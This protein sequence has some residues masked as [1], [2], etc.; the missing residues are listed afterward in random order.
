MAYDNIFDAA[1]RQFNVDP[2]LLKAQMNVESGGNTNAVSSAGAQ[3]PMQIM[4]AT[5][6]ALGVTN[7]NDPTQAIYGAAKL[8]AENLDRYGNVADAVKAYHGGTD[9][10]AWGPKTRAYAQKVQAQY[11][12]QPAQG[13]APANQDFASQDFAAPATAQPVQA[14]Q[15]SQAPAPSQNN[16]AAEDFAAP[17]AAASITP[18][19]AAP[20]NPALAVGATTAGPA[21]GVLPPSGGTTDPSFLG[22]LANYQQES[23]TG[24]LEGITKA[25]DAPAE[26]LAK[27]SQA[28]GLTGLLGQAGID[29]PTYD[30]QVA[31]DAARRQ[32]FAQDHNNL[33]AK[34]GDFGGQAAGVMVPVGGAQAALAKGGNA[35]LQGMRAVPGIAAVAPAA[36]AA[37]T[38]L[39]GG[40]GLAS[41]VVNGAAQGAAGGAQLTGGDPNSSIEGSA[42]TGAVLGGALP[43]VGSALSYGKNAIQ[44]LVSPFTDAGRSQIAQRAISGEASKDPLNLG[45]PLSQAS[46]PVPQGA[47]GSVPDALSG[48]TDVAGADAGSVIGRAG[49]GGR[50]APNF[51]E[52]VPGSLP[53]LAQ[54]T[55]N[56]G[57]AALE[58][59][60]MSR[61]PNAFA[62]RQLANDSARNDYLTQITGTPDTLQAAVNARE[63]Q[64]IPLLNQAMEGSTPVNPQPVIDTINDILKSPAGQRDAVSSALNAV[65]AKIGTGD[66]AVTDP[67]QL[68]GIRKSINDQLANV[69]GRDNSAAQLASSQLQQVKSA[70]DDTIEQGAPG[71]SNYLQQYSDL[72]SPINA[73]QYLQKLDLTDQTSQKITLNK[74]KSALN[75]INNLRAAP[76]ANAA[77]SI[78]DDQLSAL[79]N[80][81][82]DLQRQANSSRGMA[83]G[84]NT[85]QNFATNQLID[86]MLPGKIGAVAPVTPSALG[87]AL[88]YGIGG[89]VGSGM[90]A[91]AAQHIAGI[92]GRAMNAQGPE[93]EAKLINYLLNPEG[94]GALQAAAS[95]NAPASNNLLRGALQP[96]VN[97]AITPQGNNRGR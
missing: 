86:S 29:V 96:G 67:A 23:T 65:K 33:A 50:V 10:S 13:S 39:A 52:L 81:H 19:T 24:S 47:T 82:A 87:A 5:Q 15:S 95:V 84:S 22:K 26:W 30:Q 61:A 44:A 28:I 37:G 64:A 93:V 66:T 14:R 43:I 56:A 41:R 48:A 8:M 21:S 27:G 80:L 78:S 46:T 69:S 4:P 76:G 55:G 91:M 7:P 16:Y 1:G 2:A 54:A 94:S 73:Q 77:K 34:I 62:E 35:L 71:F 42:L 70:L 40:G 6:Q 25:M 38:F 45:Q 49:N 53:T 92:A 9:Q 11:G 18:A 68:Y 59:A 32:Q 20:G 97:S 36:E 58:R 83:I 12:A 74:V 51:D 75:Q 89:P 31:E 3:G 60:A 85:F 17:K 63:A 57:V 88:G 90:G 72:S 79:N